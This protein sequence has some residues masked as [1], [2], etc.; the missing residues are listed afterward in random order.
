MLSGVD[1]RKVF[2][3]AVLEDRPGIESTGY[4]ALADQDGGIWVGN[5]DT[6]EKVNTVDGVGTGQQLWGFDAYKDQCLV[7]TKVYPPK[8]GQG[9][10][11]SVQHT[12]TLES[13]NTLVYL[14]QAYFGKGAAD[15]EIMLMP[16]SVAAGGSFWN[17]TTVDNAELI[18]LPANASYANNQTNADN[19]V[20]FV[21]LGSGSRY[22]W[23]KDKA[24]TEVVINP[25]PANAN[26]INC[27]IRN[28]DMAM[29]VCSNDTYV[30][31]VP[32]LTT[33]T[34]AVTTRVGGIT[35]GPQVTV[36]Q[37]DGLFLAVA[38]NTNYLPF[39]ENPVEGNIVTG[40]GSTGSR[41]YY[42]VFCHQDSGIF[43]MINNMT[44]VYTLSNI[45]QPWTQFSIP[46]V[47]ATASVAGAALHQASGTCAFIRGDN[48]IVS[49]TADGDVKVTTYP[50]GTVFQRIIAV[51]PW[52]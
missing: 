27:A 1:L 34:G 49:Y 16:S 44:Y 5:P 3:T 47:T 24:F 19:P 18:A 21:S 38:A 51:E 40:G 25:A 14:R 28:S 35:A 13:A 10:P 2:I 11:G 37:S 46:G 4:F 30:T 12:R 41:D 31:Y 20:G 32:N 39:T 36:R 7:G 6:L 22:V 48:N 50:T 8:V 42:K 29:A 17:G 26:L 33:G 43:F 52:A 23:G 45:G 9:T 15:G